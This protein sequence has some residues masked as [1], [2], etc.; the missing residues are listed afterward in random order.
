MAEILTV[1]QYKKMCVWGG[2]ANLSELLSEYFKY[3]PWSS[4]YKKVTKLSTPSLFK[5]IK[6]RDGDD[7]WIG[8]E[9]AK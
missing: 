4:T 9:D 3:L 7:F 5:V 6:L 8:R 2:V 1:V